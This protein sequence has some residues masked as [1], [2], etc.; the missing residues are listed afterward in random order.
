LAAIEKASNFALVVHNACP[1]LDAALDKLLAVQ[2]QALETITGATLPGYLRR[3]AG[4]VLFIGSTAVSS[5]PDGWENYVAAKN[6]SGGLINGLQ[7]RYS[8]WGLRYL[9][10]APSYVAGSFSKAHRPEDAATLLPEEV[11]EAALELIDKSELQ[12]NYIELSPLGKR[13]GAFGFQPPRSTAYTPVVTAAQPAS[14]PAGGTATANVPA[15]GGEALAA[16]INQIA[17]NLL[18]LAPTTSLAGMGVGTI[19]GWD[20]LRHIQLM[21]ELERELSISFSTEE[22]SRTPLFDSLILVCAEKLAR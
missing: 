5:F 22:V 4:T 6:A 1:P 11:A 13:A 3:Q 12:P 14:A 8:T 15:A 10:L 9:T 17:C 18:G 2:F 7:N 16:Q 19:S 20:S 21:L